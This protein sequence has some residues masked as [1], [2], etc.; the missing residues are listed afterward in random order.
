[1]STTNTDV[2]NDLKKLQEELNG[3]KPKA[4][5]TVAVKKK[6]IDYPEGFVK[7][8][9]KFGFVPNSGIDHPVPDFKDEDWH[10]NVASFIPTHDPAYLWPKD[11]LE[12]V[13]VAMNNH[14][15]CLVVGPKGTG[16]TELYRNI[17]AVLRIP[18]LRINGRGDMDSSAIFGHVDIQGG[19]MGWIDGPAPLLAK[20][21]GLLALD[22]PGA[23]PAAISLSMQWMLEKNPKVY[24][25]DK[26]GTPEEKLIV[27]T[28]NF[29]IGAT[30]NTRL[31]GDDT[32]AYVGTQPQN[33]ALIDRFL[34]FTELDYPVPS[35]EVQ[36]IYNKLGLDSG[37]KALA[38]RVVQFATSIRSA[39]NKGE[40]GHNI[41]LRGTIGIVEK[42]LYWGSVHRA[43][44][45]NYLN[46]L[47]ES[48][49]KVAT[50][51]VNKLFGR[52]S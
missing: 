21:G 25:A 38:E 37:G 31:S 33:E 22:E 9:D 29:W 48:D 28:K 12:D 3:K 52:E 2:L 50:G 6:E 49:R 42:S 11:Q 8:S 13:I 32:G 47:D 34:T 16:K 26:P 27:P 1:M 45:L 7:F 36:L 41:S 19:N 10:E 39:Y 44:K 35:D 15:P 18:Y 24:M 20:H 4:N 30:D 40:I 43:L 51:L 14:E 46:K 23:I 5:P 17:C